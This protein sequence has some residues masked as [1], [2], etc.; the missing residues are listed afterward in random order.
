MIRRLILLACLAILAYHAVALLGVR[1]HDDD[2]FEAGMVQQGGAFAVIPYYWFHWSG[3]VGYAL[4][5]GLEKLLPETWAGV[6]LIGIL[7]LWAWAC[8]QL[9]RER[10]LL[11]L[12]VTL[13]AAPALDESLYWQ[14]GATVYAL[15]LALFTLALVSVKQRRYSLI[16]AAL[17]FG[18]ATLSDTMQVAQ[19]IAWAG[20]WLML[21]AYRRVLGVTLAS[22]VIGLII[23]QLAPGNAYRRAYFPTPDMWLSFGYGL[24]ATAVPFATALRT[25][26]LAIAA[27]LVGGYMLRNNDLP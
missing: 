12:V 13:A 11:V 10:G 6:P 4:V 21:P 20:L 27:A 17:A 14:S 5:V 16:P 19:I 24:R 1:W 26:P 15:P 8:W 22:A 3:R 2:L 23:V 7:V 18:I 25:A 9:G